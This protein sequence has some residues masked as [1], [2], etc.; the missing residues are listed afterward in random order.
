MA[1]QAF[2]SVEEYIESLPEER[3]E[4]INKIRS[5]INQ[6]LDG[7]F[8]EALSYNML[9]WVVPKS[10]YP[11]GYHCTP[12]LPL[13]FI[14]LASQKNYVAL[15]HLGV[16]AQ[17]DLLAWFQDEYPKRAKYKLDMGKSCVRFKRMDD[18]PYSLIEELIE[19]M[20]INDWISLYEANIKR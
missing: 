4:A 10:K 11:A 19:K 5:I 1:K 3:R 15:Y 13:P 17:P 8:E 20:S 2:K 14:N 18:I 16:Y 6:K 12:E 7:E 9:G